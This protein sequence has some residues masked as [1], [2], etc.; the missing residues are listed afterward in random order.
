[1]RAAPISRVTGL[2][3]LAGFALTAPAAFAQGSLP[4]GAIE[5]ARAALTRPRILS[6]GAVHLVGAT[7]TCANRDA[8]VVV[9]GQ[10][11]PSASAGLR[12]ALFRPGGPPL[13]DLVV[14]SWAPTRIDAHLAA[15]VAL[16]GETLNVG[17]V[18]ARG[19]WQSNTDQTLQI[20]LRDSVFIEG[21]LVSAPCADFPRVFR[22]VAQGPLTRYERTISVTAHPAR[23]TA[24][25]FDNV[26]AGT[27]SLTA[28]ET[29]PPAV[30]TTFVRPDLGGRPGA[31]HGCA[32]P[33][34]G[35][36]AATAQ[37]LP[38]HRRAT[39]VAVVEF[40]LPGPP[41]PFASGPVG[42]FPG[43]PTPAVH[44]ID[45][46]AFHPSLPTP[47]RTPAR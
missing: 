1:M 40:L 37:I 19:D 34:L 3:A 25:R 38:S 26:K 16:E 18:D 17:L 2:A 15:S 21:T 44:V 28:V 13:S 24:F 47:T 45:P 32:G 22:L 29:T 14:T 23:G 6:I 9:T 11:L 12:V 20:C 8:M 30:P 31:L 7:V 36:Q 39:G 4:P 27:Y 35:F 5:T 43:T 10:Y 41:N 42:G 46:S 33:S